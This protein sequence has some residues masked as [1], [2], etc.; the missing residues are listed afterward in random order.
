MI[1]KQQQQQQQ[2]GDETVGCRWERLLLPHRDE[3]STLEP[4][5][6]L[7]NQDEKLTGIPTK[8]YR[9]L[10]FPKQVCVWVL[11]RWWWFSTMRA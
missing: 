7:A 3:S 4:Q 2:Q 5:R 1:S 10:L 6:F 11:L 9:I 8:R